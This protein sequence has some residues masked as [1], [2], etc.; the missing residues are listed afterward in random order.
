MSNLLY[1]TEYLLLS[2]P[3][4]SR[5]FLELNL[6]SVEGREE[7]KYTEKRSNADAASVVEALVA[8]TQIFMYAALREIPRKA[9]IFGILLDRAQV[10]LR[11][12]QEST[13]TVWERERSLNLLLWVLLVACSV[14]PLDDGR[15][16]WISM[17]SEVMEKLIIIGKG[18]L[19]QAV[20][21]VSWTDTFFDGLLQRVWEEVS[22]LRRE[23]MS[24]QSSKHCSINTGTAEELDFESQLWNF[25]DGVD[26]SV[27]F[28]GGQWKVDGWFV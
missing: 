4:Y 12:P 8:S 13:I 23:R 2:I 21:R 11:S 5:E 24:Q 1:E 18:E 9:K 20:K 17:I 19:E 10:A 7:E 14:V 15:S 26:P 3:D 27:E 28:E 6:D 22:Q 16:W 25:A